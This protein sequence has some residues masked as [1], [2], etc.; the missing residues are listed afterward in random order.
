MAC[1]KYLRHERERDNMMRKVLKTVSTKVTCATA[2][3]AAGWVGHC[4]KVLPAGMGAGLGRRIE[5]RGGACFLLEL[6]LNDR[7]LN[8]PT[9]FKVQ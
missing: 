2:K 8:P 3:L 5:R 4:C 1:G 7:M 6:P 9:Q